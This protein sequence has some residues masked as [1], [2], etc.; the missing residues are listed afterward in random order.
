MPFPKHCKNTWNKHN[1]T[2]KTKSQQPCVQESCYKKLVV[3]VLVF[4]EFMQNTG[5]RQ[6]QQTQ[7]VISDTTHDE[8]FHVPLIRIN[9][10][11]HHLTDLVGPSPRSSHIYI[12]I[13]INTY[14]LGAFWG[15]FE[16][17]LGL[18]RGDFW[19]FVLPLKMTPPQRIPKTF[20][21]S[22][23]CGG[24]IFGLLSFECSGALGLSTS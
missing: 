18:H 5:K 12:S 21:F 13:I 20:V 11:Q 6:G 7:T 23:R 1:K 3:E 15:A 19:C 22:W 4:M 14:K 8:S 2:T 24:V 9:I 16:G 10:N 17:F